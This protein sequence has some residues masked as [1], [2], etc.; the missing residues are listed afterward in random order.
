M[1]GGGGVWVGGE[2]GKWRGGGEKGGGGGGRDGERRETGE[3]H[4]DGEENGREKILF[5][6]F[7]L[8][9]SFA[10]PETR[11]SMPG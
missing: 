6:Y 5:K 2:G 1:S 7:L 4:R 3:G 10:L 11:T 9:V 8:K